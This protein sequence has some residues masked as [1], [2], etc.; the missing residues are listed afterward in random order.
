MSVLVPGS[1]TLATTPMREAAVAFE[2]AFRAAW[3]AVPET[4]RGSITHCFEQRPGRVHLC[5]RMDAGG[6]VGEP[7]GR[8]TW[9]EKQT[10]LTFLAPFFLVA[11]P[12]PRVAVIVHELAHCCRR[13]SGEWTKDQHEEEVGTHRLALQWGFPP[14]SLIASGE[15]WRWPDLIEQWRQEHQNSEF[16]R[17]L[18]SGL[19]TITS[20]G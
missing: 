19:V 7:Y 11:Q 1:L 3:A 6:C 20:D 15:P 13:G 4:G 9:D 8:C 17:E 5:Y 10:S 16:T 18:E 2:D 12:E 14:P